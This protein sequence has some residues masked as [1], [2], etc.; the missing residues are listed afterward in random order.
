MKKSNGLP[1]IQLAIQQNLVLWE[2]CKELWDIDRRLKDA[3]S[4]NQTKKQQLK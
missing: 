2:V 4:K 3:H 1:F